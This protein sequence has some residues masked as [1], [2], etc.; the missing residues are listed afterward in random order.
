MSWQYN[1]KANTEIDGGTIVYNY[2][3]KE[4][5][6]RIKKRR[7]ELLLSREKLA[8][9]LDITPKFCSDIESGSRGFSIA[10]L[11]KLMD[12]LMLSSDYIL[13]GKNSKESDQVFLQLISNCPDSQ[14]SHLAKI[15]REFIDS[16][17]S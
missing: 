3:K 4:I 15:I 16:H 7:E 11:F 14:K 10:T 13:I 8:E 12:V 1:L 17:N 9:Q 6:E 2:D 5:G